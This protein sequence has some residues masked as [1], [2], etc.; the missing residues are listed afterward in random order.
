MRALVVELGRKQPSYM[1]WAPHNRS[2]RSAMS[3]PGTLTNTVHSSN[4]LTWPATFLALA[5][6]H[7]ATMARWCKLVAR[8]S[9]SLHVANPSNVLPTT[10]E[11]LALPSG[12]AVQLTHAKWATKARCHHC[13]TRQ[14]L[15]NRCSELVQ[16][17]SSNGI[18]LGAADERVS[19]RAPK[20]MCFVLTLEAAHVGQL[21]AWSPTWV[22]MALH[23]VTEFWHYSTFDNLR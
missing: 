1:C 21:M 13:V 9:N 16:M 2:A 10:S 6:A 8:V 17:H 20:D 7:C 14:L 3:I 12:S 23:A 19:E 22:P 18:R 15:V 11:A 5:D 4:P